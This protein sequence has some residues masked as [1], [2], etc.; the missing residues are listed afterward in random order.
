M[1][2]RLTDRL[3]CPRCGPAFG[4][5]LWSD[6][7]HDGRIQLGSFACPNCR[8]RYPIENGFADFA[9]LSPLEAPDPGPDDPEGAL[10][11]AAL[12]GV[13]EGPG[14]LLLAGPPARQAERIAAMVK[15]VE[16]VALHPGLRHRAETS[17]VS[18]IR[19]ENRLP[20]FS[21]TFRGVALGGAWAL[22][23]LDEAFRVVAPGGRVVFERA[24]VEGSTVEGA[25]EAPE[26]A[27]AQQPLEPSAPDHAEQR[28]HPPPQ[29][30]ALEDEIKTRSRELLLV[31]DRVIVALR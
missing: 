28:S 21:A 14:F 13:H 26:P 19:A 9:P 29:G 23:L 12:L 11:T 1:D 25:N 30:S 8:D 6:A 17:G 18:R 15:G 2:P 10:R 3:A 27:P 7:A 20:F 24:T 31:T 22:P 16:V 4:L 5:L